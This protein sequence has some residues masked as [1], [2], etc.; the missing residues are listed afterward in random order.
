MLTCAFEKDNVGAWA[1]T[2]VA[3]GS[4][5]HRSEGPVVSGYW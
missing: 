3:Y 2:D 5:Q 1:V 4:V